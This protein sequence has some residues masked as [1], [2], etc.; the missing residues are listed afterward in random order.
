M[1]AQGLGFVGRACRSSKAACSGEIAVGAERM[2][3]GARSKES[4]CVRRMLK[5]MSLY[6][7]RFG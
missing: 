1:A 5:N 6:S 7:E 3:R 2:E 4:R